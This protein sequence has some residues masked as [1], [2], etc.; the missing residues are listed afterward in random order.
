MKKMALVLLTLLLLLPFTAAADEITTV[1]EG[2]NV[3][4]LDFFHSPSCPHCAVLDEYFTELKSHYGDALQINK[5]DVATN[6]QLFASTQQQYGVPT[7]LWS[8]I[9]KVFVQRNNYYCIG[10]TPCIDGCGPGK[11]ID[12]LETGETKPGIV[13]IIENMHGNGFEPGNETDIDITTIIGL[14]A[15]DAVNPCALAVLIILLTSIL[16]QYPTKRH[17]ALHAGL[18]FTLAVFLI[19]F[20][21]G[22]L[23]IFGFKAVTAVTQLSSLWFYKVLAVLAIIIGVLNIKDFF[24]YGAGGFLMEM[25]RGWR[26]KMKRLITSVTSPAGAFFVGVIVSLFLLPCTAGPYF[27]AGGILANLEWTAAFLPLL[28]YNIIFVLPMLAITFIIYLGLTTVGRVSV[29]RDSNIRLLHLVAG[30]ILVGLGVAMLVG[31][32]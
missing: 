16:I 12:C 11:A 8:Y 24:R 18:M 25:P 22:L 14:A 20:G 32:I 1:G 2:D 6:S 31:W 21:I 27:V 26:P 17:K 28:L 7:E 30:L 23:I 19:Y 4:V 29:W 15:V 9:P 3:T 5:Y 13:E 10:D